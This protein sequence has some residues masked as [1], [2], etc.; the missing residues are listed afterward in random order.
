M[1][2]VEMWGKNTVWLPLYN[3]YNGVGV[4]VH[5]CVSAFPT[6]ASSILLSPIH[7]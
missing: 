4:G 7:H 5:A 6:Q 1:K 2:T 3:L